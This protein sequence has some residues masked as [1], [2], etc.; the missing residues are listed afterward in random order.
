MEQIGNAI[1]KMER[2]THETAASA[3]QSASAAI[4]LSA[5]SHTLR[6][7]ANQLT[8]IV[9]GAGGVVSS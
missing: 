5:Q 1:V 4:E 7:V 2:V 8:A 3:E 6:D 9:Y